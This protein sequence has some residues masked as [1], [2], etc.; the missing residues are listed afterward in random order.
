M[1]PD[2]GSCDIKFEIAS[3]EDDSDG[4]TPPKQRKENQS[5]KFQ[6]GY[7]KVGFQ[8]RYDFRPLRASLRHVQ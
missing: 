4:P 2:A 3:D 8:K 7:E 1:K 5:G 6:V